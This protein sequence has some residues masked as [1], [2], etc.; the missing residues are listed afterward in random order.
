MLLLSEKLGVLL[1]GKVRFLVGHQLFSPRLGH[2]SGSRSCFYLFVQREM[3]IRLTDSQEVRFI[4]KVAVPDRPYL[5][6]QTF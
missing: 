4:A 3:K 6:N 2:I 1:F 5:T